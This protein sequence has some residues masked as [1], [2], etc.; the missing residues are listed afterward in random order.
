MRASLA[1]LLLVALACSRR[2]S[3]E[4]K[5]AP[6]AAATQPQATPCPDS[7]AARS[8][9]PSDVLG[10]LYERLTALGEGRIAVRSRLGEPRTATAETHPNDYDPTQTDTLVQWTHD[11]LSFKFLVVVGKGNLLVETRAAR[12]YPA[13]ASLI[14]QCNTL[15]AAE[16]ALGAPAWTTVLGDTMVYGYNIP[17][18]ANA[19]TLHFVNDH[20]VLVAAA[21]FID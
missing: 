11:H 13:I 8:P 21:P 15:E 10:E 6:A 18:S 7:T 4:S 17:S 16:S 2:N 3:V 5:R 9:Q 14:S 12:D 19:V 1:A 20:L